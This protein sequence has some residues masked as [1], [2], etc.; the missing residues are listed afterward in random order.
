MK[1]D[2]I[3]ELSIAPSGPYIGQ[4]CDGYDEDARKTLQKPLGT[5]NRYCKA[6]TAKKNFVPEK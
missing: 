1:F 5:G 2:E 6:K 3:H 4:L